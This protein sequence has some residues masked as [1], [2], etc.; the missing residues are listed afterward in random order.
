MNSEKPSAARKGLAKKPVAQKPRRLKKA[1]QQSS[2]DNQSKLPE[3]STLALTGNFAENV[4]IVPRSYSALILSTGFNEDG[5]KPVL[6]PFVEMSLN[7]VKQGEV[8]EGNPPSDIPEIFSATLP[9]ENALWLSFDML[10]DMRIATE[11]LRDLVSGSIGM[12]QSRMQHARFFAELAQVE[13]Q[14]CV[15]AIDALTLDE[16]AENK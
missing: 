5:K 16:E 11:R 13:A 10:R 3:L 4:T 12:D 15:E 1:D 8:P 2:Q 6:V 7:G 14:K 9:Y